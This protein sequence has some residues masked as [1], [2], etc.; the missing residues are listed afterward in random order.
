MSQRVV[1]HLTQWSQNIQTVQEFLNYALEAGAGPRSKVVYAVDADGRPCFY[2]DLPAGAAEA[3][4]RRTRTKEPTK[5]Q[6]AVREQLEA[7][8][9]AVEAGERVSGHVPPVAKGGK[10]L[11]VKRR[12]PS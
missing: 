4:K 8:Q 1:M 7:R 5:A 9:A 12:K 6:K 11:R 10:V 2:V 3:M